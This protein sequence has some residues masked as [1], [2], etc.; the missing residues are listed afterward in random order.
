MRCRLLLGDPSIPAQLATTAYCIAAL[1]PFRYLLVSRHTH[2]RIYGRALHFWLGNWEDGLGGRMDRS[3]EG[4]HTYS[5]A[6]IRDIT[7]HAHAHAHASH[8]E[9]T[10]QTHSSQ[11]T[12]YSTTPEHT[13]GMALAKS[14]ATWHRLGENPPSNS[15]HAWEKKACLRS[16]GFPW[17]F[18]SLQSRSS[19]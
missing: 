5:E 11:V 17:F 12:L 2:A 14:M 3:K 16:T 10:E 6:W 9:H 1:L 7:Q 19:I 15:Q 18:F 13:D 8:I 4:I